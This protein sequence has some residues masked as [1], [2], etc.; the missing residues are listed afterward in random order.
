MEEMV[1]SGNE[2][3]GNRLPTFNQRRLQ[4]EVQ[5][6]GGWEEREVQRSR[7]RTEGRQRSHSREPS[8]LGEARKKRRIEELKEEL[9]LLKEGDKNKDEQ[10]RSRQSRSHSGSCGS[11]HP[12]PSRKERSRGSN[13]RHRRKVSPKR[14]R[15]KLY[16]GKSDP[17][18]HLSRFRQAMAIHNSNDAL[19]CREM[20]E[21]FTARFITNTRKPKEIDSLLALTMKVGETLKSYSTRYS[22]VYNDIDACDEDIVVKTFRFGLHEDSKLRKKAAQPEPQPESRRAK[23]AKSSTGTSGTGICLAVYTTFKE[24]IYRLLPLIKDKPY[25]EWPPKMPG[26][27]ATRETK[28]YCNYHRERGHL[29]ERCRAYKYHLEHLVKNGHLKQ[30]VDESKSPH[31]NVEVA[32]IN[33]KASAPVGIIDVIHYE[34]T[35]HDQRGE[36]RRAAHLR[37]VFQVQDSAQMAPSPLRKE[38]VEEIVFNNQDFEGVQLPY[39]DAL[40]IT[41][42]IGEFDVKRILIDLGSSVEIMYESLFRGLGL[43]KKDLSRTEGPLSGFSG[44]TVVPSGKVTI[45]VRAGTVSSPTEFF[46][47]NAFSPY[48]AI[49]GR[50]WL[51]RMGAVPSTLHQRL[52]FPTPQGVMEIRGDQLNG[53]DREERH[54]QEKCVEKLVPVTIA[55]GESQ[56]QFL[57]GDSLSEEHKSQLLALLDKY[58]DVFAWTPYEAPGVDPEFVCHELNVSPEYK[59]WLSNTVVVKKKNGKWRVCVDFT[60]LNKACP[61]DPFP[62]PKI[63]QLVDSTAGHERM[64]FLDAFQ[65]YHQIALRKEDQEKTA[66]ITPR[67]VFCYK[68]MPFGL[69]NAGAT[70]QRMVTKMFSEQLGKTVEVYIYDMVVKSVKGTDHVEDLEQVFGILRRHNLKL[71]ASK[72]EFGVGSGK[73]LGFMVTQRG[74]EANLDQIAAIQGLQPPKNVREVQRL[75]GMAAALNRFISKSAE[76]CR[77]FFDLIKKEKRFACSEESDQAFERLKKYLS[78]P[79][80][81]SSPK[82]GE[83]L[84]IYLAAS[85]KAVSAAIIRNDSGEQRSVYYTS[86]TMNGAETR[87]LPLEK[88]ALALFVTAKKLPHYFQAH[89]MIVLTSLPLKALFRSSDFSGRISKWGAQLGTYDVRYKPRTTIKG[90]VLDDFIAEF[91]PDNDILIGG[92]HPKDTERDLE[93]KDWALYVDGAANSRG[94]GLGI[95]LISPKGELL[96]MI[97]YMDLA[98]NLLKGFH[99]FNIERVGREHNGYADSLAGLASSVAPDF[100]RTITVEVQDSP[101]IAKSGQTSICQI[102]MGPS[103]MD[104]ILD[105]LSKDILP[106]DQKEAAKIRKTATRRCEKCQL[107]APAIHTPASHLNPISS[108]WS[109]AQWGLDLVGPL[110]RATG[111]RKW[112]IVA[113][114]YFTKWVEAEPLVHI[115]DSES[116]KFVWKNIITRFGI[117]RCLVSDN[118][119]PFKKYCS[120]FGIRNHFSSPAYPQGNGQAESSNKIIL[121]GIKKRLEEAKGRWVEELPTVLWTFR[122]TPQSST[123]ETPFSLTYGVEAV[124]PLEVGLPTLRSEEYDQENNEFMLAKDLDLAQECRD[125]AMIRLASYQ[126]DLKKRYDK[127]VSERILAPGDLVL[128]KVLGSKKNPTQGKLGANWEGPYQIVSEARLRAFNLKGMDDKPLKRPWNISNLKK[129]FVTYGAEIW[130]NRSGIKILAT[131]RSSACESSS[132]LVECYQ[133]TLAMLGVSPVNPQMVWRNGIKILVT[134]RSSACESLSGL[135]ERYQKTLAM[136]GVSPVNP[137]MVWRNGIKIL[138]TSRSSACESPS[139]LVERH[140]SP[141]HARRFACKPSSGVVERH[142]DPSS[143]RYTKISR[144]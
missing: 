139:G 83:P 89:T 118:G 84:Y 4:S 9:K 38:S 109:F 12:A 36:M 116:R 131:S 59:P 33:V 117:P 65:G 110:P 43:G 44:E 136:L 66:F 70:Y 92:E 90:H 6:P 85:D 77:P 30:F 94:S 46:V 51:H 144:L 112:L 28:P 67:G 35:C 79:P 14:R 107:F 29:T 24:P 128:R 55:E 3:G 124:I 57:I 137:Q 34:S 48:N 18:G 122:I 88:S 129:T 114:D 135:V 91:A 73:F 15:H 37:E 20:S 86:K 64:S 60:D 1:V 76:K 47:L 123:G 10:R 132:G 82:E 75:T 102:E 5:V 16:D 63:D 142:Q 72:C 140:Q 95:V 93:K 39:S 17:V 53:E 96:E 111:N 126:G 11:P 52:R 58:Q 56:R 22:E 81:L 31:Q 143:A 104:P 62:L 108:P 130:I 26:D 99:E 2:R 138:A 78:A 42:R 133:K 54:P 101:S 40:V 50:P 121:N 87:Y 61:K 103:W 19:M 23:K 127:S 97:A 98:K 25:F 41:L 21:I 69:K 80:L 100:R 7:G 27:P 115:T 105:Y 141:S 68:V 74:I 113:T 125:L 106:A 119:T 8:F 32:R 71:N 134:S 45:N 120:E 49:L 13:Y